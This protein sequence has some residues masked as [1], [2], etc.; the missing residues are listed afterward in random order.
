MVMVHHVLVACAS[1]WG[2]DRGT[3]TTAVLPQGGP[4]LAGDAG[5]G[6]HGLREEHTGAETLLKC[7]L[8]SMSSIAIMILVV[9]LL[10]LIIT[11]FPLACAVA[12][13]VFRGF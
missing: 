6:R 4:G 10:P 1:N 8:A 11:C 12:L 2:S 3:R 9:A 7:I 13:L 5:A